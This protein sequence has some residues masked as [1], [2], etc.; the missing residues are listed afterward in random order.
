MVWATRPSR[1]VAQGFTL[2]VEI[3]EVR[4]K[5]GDIVKKGDVLMRGRDGPIQARLVAQRLRSTNN[6]DVRAATS[7]RDL[8]QIRFDAIVQAREENGANAAEF[9][10]RR[11]QL[12]QAK[13][14]VE[15]AN[16]KLQ[17]EVLAVR[18][19]EEELARYVLTAP[20]DG[21]ADTVVGEVGQAATE[22]SPVLR[23]VN[24]DPL[25]VDAP[26]RF[27]QTVRDNL[28]PGDAAWVLIDTP[29]EATILPGRVL[30][31]SPVTDAVNQR[32]VRV[33]ARNPGLLPAG[34]PARVRFQPVPT[35]LE[36][37]IVKPKATAGPGSPG[38]EGVPGAGSGQEAG[39]AAGSK[40]EARRG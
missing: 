30:S 40:T 24:I 35:E 31:V 37:L 22:N 2:S 19:L 28:K 13:I 36:R 14:A 21:I 29:G 10:E 16:M 32:R 11:V 1:D 39:G 9:D 23:L 38:G 12:E 7:A 33:E 34:T 27:E 5:P 6:S 18:Q 17:E 8:A 26:V 20:F 3:V 4:V 25:W 15:A